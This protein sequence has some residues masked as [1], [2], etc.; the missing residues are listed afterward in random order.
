MV[1]HFFARASSY[2]ILFRNFF[3]YM[4]FLYS[5]PSVTLTKM[6]CLPRLLIAADLGKLRVIFF[7]LFLL[8]IVY[9]V[10]LSE[11]P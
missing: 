2:A 8:K 4:Y 3:Q 10:Y 7:F 6:A 1:R 11:S 5:R 9:C